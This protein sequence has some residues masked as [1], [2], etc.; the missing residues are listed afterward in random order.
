MKFT[1]VI[2]KDPIIYLPILDRLFKKGGMRI[3]SLI[4]VPGISNLKIGKKYMS[5][6]SKLFGPKYMFRL[7]FLYLRCG[8]FSFK[9]L[10]K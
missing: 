9:I 8:V 6:V 4:V 3:D 1:F 10:A 2:T 5:V 7:L